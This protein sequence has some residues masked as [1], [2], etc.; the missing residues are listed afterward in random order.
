MPKSAPLESPFVINGTVIA[1][2]GL[3]HPPSDVLELPHF[4]LTT[5]LPNIDVNGVDAQ[6][7]AP[8]IRDCENTQLA[9]H[10]SD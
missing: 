3:Q 9:F 6:N 10:H 1:L 8:I 2:G 4:L 7:C 5:A